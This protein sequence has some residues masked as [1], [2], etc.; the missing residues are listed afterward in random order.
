MVRIQIKH[1]LFTNRA[2]K[3]ICKPKKITLLCLSIASC[4]SLS[5]GLLMVDVL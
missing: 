1:G 4:N 3:E 2:H 5:Y